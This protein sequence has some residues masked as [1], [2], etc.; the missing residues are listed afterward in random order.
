MPRPKIHDSQRRRAAEACS[1]CRESKKKCSGTAPCTQCQRRGL[2]QQ[3][4]ITYLPRGFRSTKSH[5]GRPLR[6][7]PP[8]AFAAP[9]SARSATTVGLSSSMNMIG[10]QS[11]QDAAARKE[12][13]G[14]LSPSESREGNEE[15][16]AT[17]RMTTRGS[18]A[19][20]V[21]L[22]TPGPR[23][24]L[25]S[26]GERGLNSPLCACLRHFR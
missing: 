6:N 2:S 5:A 16:I 12:P 23:M 25:S 13:S 17:T 21:H 11:E 14:P 18:A 22:E 3:C 8:Q 20:E 15:S 26:H 19:K 9:A 4:F 7:P 1:T 24:L 10:P